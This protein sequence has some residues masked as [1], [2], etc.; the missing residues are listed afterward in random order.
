ML[1][2]VTPVPVVCVFKSNFTTATWQVYLIKVS[3]LL[4]L[5]LVI[6]LT[7]P[8]INMRVMVCWTWQFSLNLQHCLEHGDLSLNYA[9]YVKGCPKI[10][11]KSQ[12]WKSQHCDV[13][14]QCSKTW[15]L[16]I[17]QSQKELLDLLQCS[18]LWH[19][20]LDNTVLGDITQLYK[21]LDCLMAALQCLWYL[22]IILS[23][24]FFLN[25]F[26]SCEK[27]RKLFNRV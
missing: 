25:N 9:E 3:S 4:L 6:F 15:R 21:Q 20:Q 17:R 1:S 22:W 16:Q 18:S 23:F 11:M 14:V 24:C 8:E 13:L 19:V 2:L 7:D 10:Q 27:F 12:K 26:S 5:Y